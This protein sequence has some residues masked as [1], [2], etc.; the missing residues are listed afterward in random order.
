MV[1]FDSYR[2]NKSLV[3]WAKPDMS[4]APLYISGAEVRGLV[5]MSELTEALA[6]AFQWFSTGKV[7]QKLRGTTDVSDHAGWGNERALLSKSLNFY[8]SQKY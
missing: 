4:S 3:S 5:S 1:G 7:V 2:H 6:P 8:L